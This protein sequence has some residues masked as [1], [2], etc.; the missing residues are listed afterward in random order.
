M[1]CDSTYPRKRGTT[2]NGTASTP[3]NGLECRCDCKLV[4]RLTQTGATT[5]TPP[6]PPQGPRPHP[7]DQTTH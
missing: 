2:A 6:H 5:D 7:M 4:R 3:L 1:C